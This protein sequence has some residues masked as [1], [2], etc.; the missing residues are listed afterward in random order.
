MEEFMKK[1]LSYVMSLM[2]L[3]AVIC[4]VSCANP[5]SSSGGGGNNGESFACTVKI[6]KNFDS[7]SITLPQTT[8]EKDY[9]KETT[10]IL[11]LAAE[12]PG[13]YSLNEYE[14]FSRTSDGLV[15]NTL[16]NTSITLNQSTFYISKN[17][18]FL[19]I[20]NKL[21]IPLDEYTVDHYN[22]KQND[23][24][25]KYFPGNAIQIQGDTVLYCFYKKTSSRTEAEAQ[26][27]A[28]NYVDD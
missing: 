3:L 24:G 17:I 9:I 22:T 1:I 12:M 25:T 10:D 16:T 13:S 6:I 28:E 8:S 4:F 27:Y 19:N 26:S 18:C 2:A 11:H 15:C 7:V 20:N 14:G 23:T 5:G 21:Y